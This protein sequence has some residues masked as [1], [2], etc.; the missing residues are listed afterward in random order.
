M[1]ENNLKG[2]DD[3]STAASDQIS[4]LYHWQPFDSARL[5]VILRDRVIYCSDPNQFN[6]PWDCKPHFNTAILDDPE[7]YEHHVQWILG[8]SRRFFPGLSQSEQTSRE[9][10]LRSDRQFLE[11]HVNEMSEDMRSAITSRYRV[12]CLCPDALNLLMWAHYADSHKG[13][14]LEFATRNEVISKAIAVT[15]HSKFPTV[16]LY[17]STLRESLGPLLYKA[18]VWEYEQEYRLIAQERAAATDHETLITENNFLKLPKSALISVIAGCRANFENVRAV[19]SEV[20][21]TFR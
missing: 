20:P 2:M 8:V 3:V 1:A 4:T 12:Y 5:K 10:R 15:Y 6:D 9:D 18:A 11:W 14:C 7:E 19:V 16:R 13:I 17:A 21:R